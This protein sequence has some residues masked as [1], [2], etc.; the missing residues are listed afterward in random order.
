M[1]SSGPVGVFSAGPQSTSPAED[2]D[3]PIPAG[4]DPTWGP[5]Q[6]VAG[7]LAASASY[8]TFAATARQYLTAPAAR[9]WD[10]SG[11]GVTVYQPYRVVTQR[12]GQRAQVAVTGTVQDRFNSSGEFVSASSPGRPTN[13]YAFGLVKAGGLWRISDPPPTRLVTQTEFSQDF[14]PQDLY[15]LNPA[16]QSPVLVPD[17]VFVPLGTSQVTLVTNLVTALLQGPKGTWLQDATIS[18]PAGTKLLSVTIDGPTAVVDLGGSVAHVTNTQTLEQVS[19]QLLWTLA[20]P[21]A[22]GSSQIQSVQ[23]EI[24]GKA[25]IPATVCG[26]KQSQSPVQKQA[27]YACYDPYPARQADFSFVGD[28]TALARCGLQQQ[29]AANSIGKVVP[30]FGRLAGRSCQSGQFVSIGSPF[31]PARPAGTATAVAV[32]PDWQEAAYVSPAR[33]TDTLYIRPLTGSAPAR[34]LTEPGAT[35][36]CWDRQDDLWF[37]QGGT[38]YMVPATGGPVPVSYQAPGPGTVVGLKIAPDG[39]RIALIVQVGSHRQLELG[40]IARGQPPAGQ[41]SSPP[42]VH[43][44]IEPGVQLGPNVAYP[45]SLTWYDADDLLVLAA[46]GSQN[47][48]YEVPVDGQQGTAEPLTPP[49]AT[50]I[51][52]YGA[53]NALVAGL[54]S[55]KLAVS[56]SLEGPWL[57]LG[58]PGQDPAY[59]G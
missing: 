45:V 23:L 11:W 43:P 18:F 32:S 58:G 46:T 27:A 52:A 4:P 30:V 47:T 36:L 37:I 31:A 12:A 1:P 9:R 6:I 2:F 29:V 13:T 34:A 26:N 55:N 5:Q 20:N 44:W 42:A 22:S 21:Q 17:S 25:F 24:D 40:V 8:P 15:F 59:P 49:G 19:A 53:E 16:G 10:P 3:G 33:G 56:A 50:S 35:S 48:L 7:F 14:K 28:G 57:T 39:A 38:V 41:P 54:S 51:A